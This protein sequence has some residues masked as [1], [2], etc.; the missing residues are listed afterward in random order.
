M[1]HRHYQ[2]LLPIPPTRVFVIMWGLIIPFRVH[3]LVPH[4]T[5]G[6]PRPCHTCSQPI[7]F[8]AIFGSQ[9]HIP[10]P[11]A[12]IPCVFPDMGAHGSQISCLI[13][14]VNAW[15]RL[16]CPADVK[17]SVEGPAL[18]WS[19]CLSSLSSCASSYPTCLV[20]IAQE[21]SKSCIYIVGMVRDSPSDVLI[22]DVSTIYAARQ[23]CKPC[24][25]GRWRNQSRI[26]LTMLRKHVGLRPISLSISNYMRDEGLF[27]NK[28]VQ[29]MPND[30]NVLSNVCP[31]PPPPPTYSLPTH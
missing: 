7:T 31:Q 30:N 25:M 4:H 10:T 2:C 13:P 18:L 24:F 17:S 3:H 22:S 14:V 9:S 6:H 20:F 1:V 28:S 27:L 29:L 21:L 15:G 23:L 11:H 5:Y 26:P 8:I 16:A 12:W 19:S